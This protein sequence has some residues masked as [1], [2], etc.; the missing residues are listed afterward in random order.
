MN[1]L[2]ALVLSWG[3]ISRYVLQL[4][5]WNRARC[6]GRGESLDFAFRLAEPRLQNNVDQAHSALQDETSGFFMAQRAPWTV[7]ISKTSDINR[8]WRKAEKTQLHLGLN[9]DEIRKSLWCL[10]DSVCIFL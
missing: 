4:Q 2:P 1:C 10:Q 6:K 5:P 9:H 7:Q 3:T 8:P